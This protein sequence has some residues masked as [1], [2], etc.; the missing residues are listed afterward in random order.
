VDEDVEVFEDGN[1]NAEDESKV[2]A[3][4]AE[5]GDVSQLGVC[6]ALGAARAHKADVRDEDGDPGEEAENGDEVDKV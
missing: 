6:D 3:V 2:G 1:D 5:G 4:E